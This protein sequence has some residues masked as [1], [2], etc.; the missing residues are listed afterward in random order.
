[1]KHKSGAVRKGEIMKLFVALRLEQVEAKMTV[2]EVAK[3]L[4]MERSTHLQKL[5]MDL[6]E[7]GQLTT[8]WIPHRP[9][10]MK[11]MFYL[12]LD[13]SEAPDQ[14]LIE[15]FGGRTIVINRHSYAEQKAFLWGVS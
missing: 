10:R 12:G 6:V 1:M 15:K 14:E 2:Y 13:W 11:R 4:G 7:E 8:C 9:N 5:M 3:K